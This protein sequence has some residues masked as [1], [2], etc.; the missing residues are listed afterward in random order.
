ML[1]EY[2]ARKAKEFMVNSL[3]G[4]ENEFK[5]EISYKIKAYKRKMVK[6]L[7]ALF[8]LLIALAFIAI[9]LV[10]LLTEYLDLTKTLAFGIIGIILVLVGLI[11]KVTG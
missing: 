1:K 2:L 9:A 7:I 6:D 10:F 8:I 4:M 3:S 5:K 11:I